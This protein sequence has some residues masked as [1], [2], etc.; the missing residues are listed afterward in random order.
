MLRERGGVWESRKRGTRA[1][2]AGRWPCSG[3]TTGA[4]PAGGLPPRE[5]P[6]HLRGAWRGLPAAFGLPWGA[7]RKGGSARREGR[8]SAARLHAGAAGAEPSRRPL[9]GGRPGGS[10]QEQVSPR[11]A[12]RRSPS[13]GRR[14]LPGSSWCLRAGPRG[15]GQLSLR[16]PRSPQLLLKHPLTFSLLARV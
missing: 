2:D 15:T 16:Q 4:G 13:L 1:A 7:R 5:G 3:P 12:P 11:R 9:G 10:Q 14:L 8:G 6:R